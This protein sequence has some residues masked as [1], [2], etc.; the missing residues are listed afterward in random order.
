MAAMTTHQKGRARKPDPTQMVYT[1]FFALLAALR[2]LCIFQRASY[3]QALQ[4]YLTFFLF[5]IKASPQFL[6]MHSRLL[7]AAASCR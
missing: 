3:L 4:Q 5:A 7:S 1:I 2:S 6:Q